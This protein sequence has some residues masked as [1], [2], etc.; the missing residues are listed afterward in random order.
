MFEDCRKNNYQN[1]IC[2]VPNTQ[3]N[4]GFDFILLRRNGLANSFELITIDAT[5]GSI[6]E[7][8]KHKV[9]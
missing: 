3:N 2:G 5:V 1:Y 6:E 9:T 7:K 8:L 4:E